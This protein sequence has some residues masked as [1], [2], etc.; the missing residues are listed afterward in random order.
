[1]NSKPLTILLLLN[2]FAICIEAKC[3][4]NSTIDLKTYIIDL[5]LPPRE[6]FKQVVIDFQDHIWDWFA[7][8]K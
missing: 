8:E 2:I 1:M 6:R 7:A 4:K 5:D 3:Q